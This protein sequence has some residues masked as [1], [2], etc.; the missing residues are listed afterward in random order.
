[1][2]QLTSSWNIISLDDH[3]DLIAQLV[4]GAVEYTLCFSAEG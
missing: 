2:I 3:Y 1:M 4:G